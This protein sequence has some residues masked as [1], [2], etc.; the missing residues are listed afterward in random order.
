MTANHGNQT[1]SNRIVITTR[2]KRQLSGRTLLVR[3]LPVPPVGF[4]PTLGRF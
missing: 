3:M 1:I 2:R 4:E